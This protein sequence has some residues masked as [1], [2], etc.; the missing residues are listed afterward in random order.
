MA[1]TA[2]D[3]RRVVV[4]LDCLREALELAR[5]YAESWAEYVA[6]VDTNLEALLALNDDM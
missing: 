1:V 3:R 6:I 2:P 5:V 4:E